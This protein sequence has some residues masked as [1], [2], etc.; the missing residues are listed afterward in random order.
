VCFGYQST[1]LNTLV[2]QKVSIATSKAQTTRRE[3]LGVLTEAN[4]QLVRCTRLVAGTGSQALPPGSLDHHDLT[5][6]ASGRV[7][8]CAHRCFMIHQAYC[9]LVRCGGGKL[10]P[11]YHRCVLSITNGNMLQHD[12]RDGHKRPGHSPRRRRWCVCQCHVE[13][14]APH[15]RHRLVAM[16]DAL[17]INTTAVMVVV[18]ATRN[19][20]RQYNAM[21]VLEQLERAGADEWP[22]ATAHSR[23]MVPALE[24]MS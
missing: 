22:N 19:V 13:C 15:S 12:A 2:G 10:C 21:F 9:I 17:D 14:H 5:S 11:F 16:R 7:S 23:F 1:L 6:F 20:D 24:M 4:V 18:D 8:G 3:T